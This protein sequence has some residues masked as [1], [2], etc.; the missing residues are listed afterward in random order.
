MPYYEKDMFKKAIEQ[1]VQNEIW[2]HTNN[3]AEA[4]FKWYNDDDT[5]ICDVETEGR[6]LTIYISPDCPMEMVDPDTARVVDSIGHWL[7]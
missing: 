5:V 6:R 2:Q 1:L 7:K 3:D 4:I